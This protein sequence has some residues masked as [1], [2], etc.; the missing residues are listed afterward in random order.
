MG[1]AKSQW[2]KDKARDIRAD[3]VL[4]TGEGMTRVSIDGTVDRVKREDMPRPSY[5]RAVNE[6]DCEAALELIGHNSVAKAR[7]ANPSR[8]I[9]DTRRAACERFWVSSTIRMQIQDSLPYHIHP[10]PHSSLHSFHAAPSIPSAPLFLLHTPSHTPPTL[11]LPPPLA[12]P[13]YSYS[14]SAQKEST[15]PQSP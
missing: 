14:P 8:S 3:S 2:H 13:N 12:Q 1:W 10:P 7:P 15:R 5:Q 6:G 4:M 9:I 11:R